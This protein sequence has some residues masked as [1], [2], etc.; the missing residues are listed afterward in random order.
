LKTLD[1]SGKY[2]AIDLE[3]ASD[4]RLLEWYN[5]HSGSTQLSKFADRETALKKCSDLKQAMDDLASTAKTKKDKKMKNGKTPKATKAK[6]KKTAAKAKNGNGKKKEAGA[7]R[8]NS[9]LADLIIVK[10]VKENP[11]REKT[12]GWKSW[13]LLKPKMTYAEFI[14][15]GG[16][17]KDLRW[18]EEKGHL[19]LS[20]K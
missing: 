18:D 15:A 14:A 19:K 13:E 1:T 12:E 20:K 4:D 5:A 17:N 9:E 10:L 6:S 2:Q 8:V 3:Q 7:P 11:R 16:R